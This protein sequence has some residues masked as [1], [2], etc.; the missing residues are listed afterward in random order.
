[1]L[2]KLKYRVVLVKRLSPFAFGMKKHFVLIA[3]ISGVSGAIS[4]M[5]PTFY[6]MFIDQVIIGRNLT[7]FKVVIAGY[8]GLFLLDTALSFIRNYSNNRLLNRTVF[9][10]KH[11]I[12]ANYFQIPFADYEKRSTGD[13]KMRIDDDVAKLADFTG[14]QTV[15]YLKSIITAIIAAIL[16]FSI[17]WRLALFSIIIVPLT[18]Y[19]DHRISLKERDLQH[20]NRENDQRWNSWLH[21]SIQGWK[22]IKALNLQKHQTKI[23]VRFSHNFAE[24]SGRWIHYW[25]ARVLVIPKI[26]DEFLMK[27]AL[28]FFGGILI[29]REEIT[30]GS[31]LVFAMYYAL[32]SGSI[33]ALSF[34]DAELQSNT[35]YY[36]RVI[37]ELYTTH[38]IKP[39]PSIP[40]GMKSDIHVKNIRFSYAFHLPLVVD[41]LSFT[42]KQGE[43]V[44]LIGR[45]GSGKSTILKLIMGMLKPSSGQIWLSDMDIHEINHRFIFERIGFIMQDNFLFNLTIRENLRLASPGADTKMLDEACRKAGIDQFIYSQPDGYE[46]VIGEKGIKLSGGQRQRIVLARLFLRDVSMIIFDEAT[47]A[48]DQYSENIIHDAICAIG[49]DKTIIVVSH[50]ESSIALCDRVINLG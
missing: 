7:V 31:L 35:P 33:R 38:P 15:D 37:Q 8:V 41:N 40:Q 46:T 9:R 5:L 30:I 14:L 50:R 1:M 34:A 16:I 27:F 45:S 32:L 10:I 26:K 6:K 4:L 2:V 11:R 12:L 44:A 22:E 13:L 23:F 39:K 21:S 36:D 20:I 18:F 48:L 3:L 24:F 25:V 47:S 28:Y 17:E 29:M 43:R 49:R 42:I 19:T